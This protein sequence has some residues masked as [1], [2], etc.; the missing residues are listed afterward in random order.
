MYETLI[1]KAEALECAALRTTGGMRELW[2][3]RAQQ[4]RE[5]ALSLTIGEA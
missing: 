4:L 2:A 1:Q 5:R 3:Y